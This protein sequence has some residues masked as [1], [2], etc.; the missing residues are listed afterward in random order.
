MQVR[1]MQR[2][3]ERE[4][5]VFRRLWRGWAFSLF[6]TP[7]LFL[8]AMGL[9]L[10]DYVDAERG[11][12]EGLSY[13]AFVAPGLLAASAMQIAAGESLWPVMGGTKWSRTFH[14]MVST[15][16]APDDVYGGFLAWT[17]IRAGMAAVVFLGVATLFGAVGS[18]WGVLAV[19]AAV[20]TAAAFAAPLVAFAATQE[21]DLRFPLVIRLGVIPLFLFSGTFFPV[22]QLP[23]WLE[24]ASVASPLW[25]GVELCRGA[26]RGSLGLA[27]AAGHVAFLGACVAAGAAWGR[28]SFTERL[29]G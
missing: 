27:A 16:I 19:P 5:L 22:D 26:M 21:T 29:A 8:A 10:G 20:L 18:P 9:G 25:H 15:P 12:V 14:G 24:P 23:G 17:A 6:V 2:V 28:R 11:T 1:S 4:V 13:L 3:V 7:T